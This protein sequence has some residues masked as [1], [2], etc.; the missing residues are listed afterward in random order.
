MPIKSDGYTAVNEN[1]WISAS[2]ATTENMEIRGTHGNWNIEIMH[3]N[4]QAD[5]II[6][7]YTVSGKE[8]K[9]KTI[10][11]SQVWGLC[12]YDKTG[13]K[14]T[15]R[16]SNIYLNPENYPFYHLKNDE[17]LMDE[18]LIVIDH[19]RSDRTPFT[20]D[21][22]IQGFSLEDTTDASFPVSMTFHPRFSFDDKKNEIKKIVLTF[23]TC[24]VNMKTGELLGSIQWETVCTPQDH[25]NVSLMDL[26]E[27]SPSAAFREAFRK[28][29]NNH[30]ARRLCDDVDC[31]EEIFWYSPDITTDIQGLRGETVSSWGE[32]I[33]EKIAE[34]WI[35]RIQELL[36]GDEVT[37][38]SNKPKPIDISE[39]SVGGGE[40]LSSPTEILH[41]SLKNI[42][43]SAVKLTW[44]GDQAGTVGGIIL[45]P[46]SAISSEDVAPFLENTDRFRN[47]FSNLDAYYIPVP[48]MHHVLESITKYEE[49]KGPVTL[50]IMTNLGTERAIAY[51]GS[52]SPEDIVSFIQKATINTYADQRVLKIFQYIGLNLGL[53][54]ISDPVPGQFLINTIE[55][56]T[57]PTGFE[58]SI[59]FIIGKDSAIK[60]KTSAIF[61][62][63]KLMS[64]SPFDVSM[65]GILTD[66]LFKIEDLDM[67][68]D[69]V[70][71]LMGGPAVNS[72]VKDLVDRGIS[73]VNW[74][75][76][77][78]E[79]EYIRGVFGTCDVLIIAGGDREATYAAV[80]SFTELLQLPIHA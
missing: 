44:S 37:I 60:D 48:L 23:E 79:Y 20:D 41:E 49:Q 3:R 36:Q 73:T 31:P 14:I 26:K 76:S 74:K 80:K 59:F 17:I 11:L 10:R 33:P 1:G 30:A 67:C 64:I 50:S 68:Y 57:N 22:F 66:D 53:I 78:G 8:K 46:Y 71:I 6:I 29:L 40:F 15:S 70:F 45:S 65:M 52:L 21:E 28:F 24:A 34:K 7:S 47:D 9:H 18:H 72:Y 43:N 16:K 13:E 4:G 42:R 51:T 5:D 35:D 63:D 58:S 19:L 25:G 62:E 77:P 75:I 32:C 54:D 39:N 12:S 55:L 2:C 38:S 69:I 27:I 56:L 61:I